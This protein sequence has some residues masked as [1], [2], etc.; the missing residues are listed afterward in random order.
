MSCPAPISLETLLSYWLGE[1]DD[2]QEAGMEEHYLGCATCSARL[3]ELTALAAEVRALTRAGGVGFVV[4][5]AFVRRLVEQGRRVREYRVP[6]NGS[7]NCTVAPDD[8]FVIA[9]LEAPL[10][11]AERID[12][13]LMHH[14]GDTQ[15]RYEDIPFVAERGEVLLSSRLDVL[16]ALPASTVHLCLIA[17]DKQGE[18]ILGDYRFNHTPSLEP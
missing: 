11:G 14:Q 7:V 15:V 17:Y 12:L 13:L 8:D 1:L 2:D 6:S 9:R 5:D 16:R 10:Q 4:S 3:E 18:R